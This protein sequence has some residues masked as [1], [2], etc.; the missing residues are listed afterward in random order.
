M[1]KLTFLLLIPLLFSSF[2]CISVRDGIPTPTEFKSYT[3]GMY[4]KTENRT[5]RVKG[6]YVD[7]EI[8]AVEKGRMYILTNK[9]VEPLRFV[10]RI[11]LQE[12]HISIALQVNDPERIKKK[13]QLIGLIHLVHG[14]WN[15]FTF[16]LTGVPRQA[17]VGRA[18]RKAYYVKY[19][20]DITWNDLSKFAR[21]PQGMPPNVKLEEIKRVIQ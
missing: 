19:P 21:F 5:R 14:W 2:S 18:V 16:P 10:D 1:S 12:A 13:N 9:N 8:I 4:I 11:T 3:Y 7:G 17:I 6:R 20:E 15:I